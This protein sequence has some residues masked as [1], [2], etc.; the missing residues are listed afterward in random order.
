MHWVEERQGNVYSCDVGTDQVCVLLL[1]KPAGALTPAHF[2]KLPPGEGPRHAVFSPDGHFLYV[3]N[4]LGNS[5]S[6][7]ALSPGPALD[8]KQTVSTQP[9]GTNP[10]G[11]TAAEIRCHPSGKWLYV[12]T[13]GLDGISVFKILSDGTLDRIQVAPLSVRFPRGF[14]IDPSGRWIVVGGERSHNLEVLAI[15]PTTGKL[16]EAETQDFPG[17]PVCILFR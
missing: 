1:D 5:V 9:E 10:I 16:A 7:L 8:L 13:R 11:V 4:E 3:G 6:T 15:D 12:S 17:A 2:A 14:D